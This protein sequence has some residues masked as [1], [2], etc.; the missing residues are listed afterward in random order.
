MKKKAMALLLTAAMAASVLTG[1]GSG[2]GGSGSQASG[3]QGGAGGLRHSGG[4]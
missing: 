2:D 4:V 1:C 3:S